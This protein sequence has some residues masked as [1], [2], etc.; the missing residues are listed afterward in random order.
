[1]RLTLTLHDYLDKYID[2][3]S[4]DKTWCPI[5]YEQVLQLDRDKDIKHV[6]SCYKEMKIEMNFREQVRLYGEV[7][8]ISKVLLRR[9]D[10]MVQE[11]I[12]AYH[13]KYFKPD[14]SG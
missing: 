1:M 10:D 14:K 4:A 12:T 13:I 7:M 5:C 8:D 6:I 2:I 9:I 3:V 11:E